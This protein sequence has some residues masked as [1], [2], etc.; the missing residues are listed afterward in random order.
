MNS[1]NS[2]GILKNSSV[3]IQEKTDFNDDYASSD[4][5]F[6]RDDEMMEKETK[7][8]SGQKNRKKTEPENKGLLNQ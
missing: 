1:K 8:H 7:M 4:P 2:K 5:N 3:P 6:D